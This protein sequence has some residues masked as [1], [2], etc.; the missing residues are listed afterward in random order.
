MPS[1]LV[2]AEESRE[3]GLEPI[4][5]LRSNGEKAPGKLLR[6]DGERHKFETFS[7]DKQQQS[8]VC[9][10]MVGEAYVQDL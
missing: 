4:N 6:H 5:F 8:T 9:L 1:P 3:A 10:S 7:L 2:N